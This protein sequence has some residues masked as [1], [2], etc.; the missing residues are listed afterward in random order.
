MPFDI[1]SY[2]SFEGYNEV[3]ANA[4]VYSDTAH[5]TPQNTQ[6]GPVRYFDKLGG[7][8]GVWSSANIGTANPPTLRKGEFVTGK[9]AVRFAGN[10]GLIDDTTLLYENYRGHN[11]AFTCYQVV[12][13]V[14]NNCFFEFANPAPGGSSA[15]YLYTELRL[16]GTSS[17]FY[18]DYDDATPATVTSPS[19][20]ATD[21]FILTRQHDPTTGKARFRINKG[22][23]SEYVSAEGANNGSAII[24]QVSKGGLWRTG[25][26]NGT[27]SLFGSFDW[28][29]EANFGAV[30]SDAIGDEI[31]D[32]LAAL[33]IGPPAAPTLT[34]TGY[35]NSN[36]IVIAGAVGALSHTIERSLN[37]STGWTVLAAETT[38]TRFYDE[39]EDLDPVNGLTANTPYY[40]RAKSHNAGGT[41]SYSSTLSKTTLS[42]TPTTYNQIIECRYWLDTDDQAVGTPVSS[43]ADHYGGSIAWE[44]ATPGFRP[45]VVN[46]PDGGGRPKVLLADGIDDRLTSDAN[47]SIGD[48]ECALMWVGALAAADDAANHNWF[49]FADPNGNKPTWDAY[50]HNLGGGLLHSDL[51]T[52]NGTLRHRGVGTIDTAFHV[53]GVSKDAAGRGEFFVDGEVSVEQ[54]FGD[55]TPITCSMATMFLHRR[56]A[57]EAP[58]HVYSGDWVCF[59]DRPSARQWGRLWVLMRLDFQT[60]ATAALD[61]LMVVPNVI[62][63]L[64]ADSAL[65][66][67]GHTLADG[68]TVTTIATRTGETNFQSAGGTLTYET[69][70]GPTGKAMLAL[71]S[72]CTIQEDPSGGIA[73]LLSGT[74]AFSAWMVAQDASLSTPQALISMANGASPNAY[75]VARFANGPTYELQSRDNSGGDYNAAAGAPDSSCQFHLWTHDGD[76]TLKW[77]VGGALKVT[78][79]TA[80][81]TARTFVTAVAGALYRGGT[82]E[83]SVGLRIGELGYAEGE[84]DVAVRIYLARYENLEWGAADLTTGALL[85]ALL[86]QGPFV[87]AAP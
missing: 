86:Q 44:Q 51:R 43:W 11:K 9:D 34:G 22:A 27:P 45:A 39:G 72:G 82:S 49:I 58:A 83:Q 17:V 55:G 10:H 59:R 18:Y 14:A 25:N 57:N 46:H 64:K 7:T 47:A 15:N 12:K 73:G 67:A 23:W 61:P 62:G 78:L 70:E 26:V 24:N 76:Q 52:N 19:P 56:E 79:T 84:V 29:Y 42:G 53:F 48:G 63:Y 71:G 16:S 77:F 37:G 36:L 80:P 41:S 40:Y 28:G 6:D 50:I 60:P 13:N 85:R 33:Y 8:K 4:T 65:S 2:P 30:H 32:N 75:W 21:A 5:T 31:V 3:V 81:S 66:A 68:S 1:T 35:A 20:G 54:I 87:G 74:D 38:R 69:G